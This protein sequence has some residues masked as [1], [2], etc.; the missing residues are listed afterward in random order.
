MSKGPSDLEL[1]YSLAVFEN[2]Q[3]SA[4]FRYLYL[5]FI[6]EIKQNTDIFMETGV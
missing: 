3:L 6:L 1:Q 5:Y 4:A 2:L